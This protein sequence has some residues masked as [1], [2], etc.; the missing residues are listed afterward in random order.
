MVFVW[1]II[2]VFY[3]YDE[4]GV[5]LRR[6]L[7]HKK[8]SYVTLYIHFYFFFDIF[9]NVTRTTGYVNVE[10]RYYFWLKKHNSFNIEI[11]EMYTYKIQLSLVPCKIGFPISRVRC[12][13][14]RKLYNRKTFIDS[15]ER[16][17]WL[18]K[19]H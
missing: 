12:F 15:F 17:I 6:K 13:D 16:P 14:N 11:F 9:P 4:F 10:I 5:Q 2:W 1:R 7:I 19:V 3:L 18:R 8:W